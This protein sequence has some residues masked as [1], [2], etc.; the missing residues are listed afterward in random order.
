MRNRGQGFDTFK[1]LIAAIV[2]LV[3]L[4]ILASILG[5]INP[6][7]LTCVGSPISEVTTTVQKATTGLT[8]TSAKLCLKEKEGFSAQAIIDRLSGVEVK[9]DCETGAVVCKDQATAKLELD[10]DTGRLEARRQ[11]EFKVIAECTG[12]VCTVWVSDPPM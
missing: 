9:F 10:K 1:L 6:S 11:V 7:Q 8:A 4:G 12:N 5:G 3:I 2:A